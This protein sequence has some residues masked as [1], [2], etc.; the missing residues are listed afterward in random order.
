MD[1]KKLES[2]H[3]SLKKDMQRRG[4]RGGLGKG[5]NNSKRIQIE[6]NEDA[7][8]APP[9]SSENTSSDPKHIFIKFVRASNGVGT[10]EKK[11][12]VN[13][14]IKTFDSD[15]ED[16]ESSDAKPDES[17]SPKI[18]LINV[19][20]G[21]ELLD[22]NSGMILNGMGLLSKAKLKKADGTTIKFD[23]CTL[24]SVS[25]N[26]DSK[27][28]AQIYHEDHGLINGRLKKAKAASGVRLVVQSN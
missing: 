2:I 22:V 18:S 19:P 14:R 24:V 11:S 1:E 6:Y 15:N 28:T 4:G 3:D 27:V 9:S 17:L 5:S 26:D 13:K 12:E 10:H 16:D 20:E 23:K 7:Y 8:V 25:T 21:E